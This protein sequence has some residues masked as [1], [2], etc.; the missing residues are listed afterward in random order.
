MNLS[1]LNP[2]EINQIPNILPPGWG[3]VIPTFIH[4]ANAHFC[5]PIK[6][7]V[8]YKIA[9]TGT[10][11]IHNNTAWLAHIIVHREYRNQGFGKLITQRLIDIA[12]AKGCDTL[13]LLATDLGEPVYKKLGFEIETEYGFFKGQIIP[14]THPP[15]KHI[16]PFH[17][18][19]EKQIAKLDHRV[20]GEDR[21]VEL[22]S[23]LANGYVY[24]QDHEV[25]GY[26]LPTCG[27]GLIIATSQAAGQELL[28]LRLT[29]KDF[30]VFP[31]DNA[32]ATAFLKK[33]DFKEV[34]REKRMR[35]G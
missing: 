18:T 19:F 16:L 11:I 4:Y 31:I 1:P 27:D 29:S 14:T 26:Y 22:K 20:S 8:D 33:H 15:N 12:K 24:V 5:F 6:L 13:Y 10:A 9:G 21:W 23:H 7:T 32:F 2:T 17:T 35:L 3:G 34:R 28:K 30:A 25:K